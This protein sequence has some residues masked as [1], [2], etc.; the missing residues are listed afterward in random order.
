MLYGFDA[1]ARDLP[2]GLDPTARLTLIPSGPSCFI[3]GSQG[4]R[5]CIYYLFEFNDFA[6]STR[7]SKMNKFFYLS[8]T[9]I[10]R[11]FLGFGKNFFIKLAFLFIPA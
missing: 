7:R 2:L 6:G 8:Y 5:Y 3:V 1:F 9:Y 4:G 11:Y 10:I